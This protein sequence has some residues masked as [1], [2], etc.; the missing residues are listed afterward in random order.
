MLSPGFHDCGA[1]DGEELGL[2]ALA[3]GVGLPACAELPGEAALALARA[4]CGG[5]V[6]APGSARGCGLPVNAACAVRGKRLKTLPA[7]RADRPTWQPVVVYGKPCRTV[8]A[9][10]RQRHGDF[11]VACEELASSSSFGRAIPYAGPL[12][13]HPSSLILRSRFPSPCPHA[14]AVIRSDARQ[15]PHPPRRSRSSLPIESQHSV[16]A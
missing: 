1:G 5:A 15:K 12:I 4:G 3:A 16:P 6:F 10:E 13:L 14:S 11:S 8:G 2:G 9:V 7:P